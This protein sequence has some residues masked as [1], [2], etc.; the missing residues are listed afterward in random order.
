MENIIIKNKRVGTGSVR[1]S[2]ELNFTDIYVC[3]R[4]CAGLLHKTDSDQK[5][6]PRFHCFTFAIMTKQNILISSH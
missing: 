4:V 2:G 5:G 6:S 1:C 3:V